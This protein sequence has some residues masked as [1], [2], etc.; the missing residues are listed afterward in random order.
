MLRGVAEAGHSRCMQVLTCN[1]A[2]P[3]GVVSEWQ[4]SSLA[5]HSAHS[6][7][8]SPPTPTSRP[9]SQRSQSH[10]HT[11]ALPPHLRLGQV[12]C[13]AASAASVA[14]PSRI[15][16]RSCGIRAFCSGATRMWATCKGA[17][18]EAGASG[19]GAEGLR[20]ERT[21]ERESGPPWCGPPAA[22]GKAATEEATEEGGGEKGQWE[23]K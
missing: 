6:P 2:C 13:S 19:Q 5:T 23:W 18:G 12:L 14:S 8:G 16:L 21:R 1:V 10:C 11:V 15:R 7:T 22:Q 20:G 17:G 4:A 9:P 3:P